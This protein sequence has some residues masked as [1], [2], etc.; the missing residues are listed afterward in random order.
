MFSGEEKKSFNEK[1][2]KLNCGEQRIFISGSIKK[3]D[4]ILRKTASTSPVKKK[5]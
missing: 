5:P 1:F 3:S 2:R 4:V